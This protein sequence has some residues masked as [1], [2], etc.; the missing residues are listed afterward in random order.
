MRSIVLITTLVLTLYTPYSPSQTTEWAF[1]LNAPAAA[2][3]LFPNERNPNAIAVTAGKDVVLI[4][5]DGTEAWR[6]TQQEAVATPATVA[7]LDSDSAPETVVALVN[8]TV[9]CLDAR[10]TEWWRHAFNT[11]AG[12]FKI[13]AAADL[14][15]EPGIET[16]AGFDDGWLNCLSARGGLLWRFYGDRFR[17]GGVA[18][19]DADR[20]GSPN[21]VYGTD[22]GHIYC[23]D[24]N[25]RTIWRYNELAPYGRSG[26]NIADLDTDG[27]PEV[28]ITR[29]NV[30]NATCLMA[31]DAETGAFRW[32]TQDV[33]QGY[34][35]SATVDLDKDGRLE[36]LHGDKGNNLYCENSD[37]SRRWKTELGG[38]GLFWAPCV[39]DVDGDRQY[40]IVAAVRDA[41]LQT[42]AC[43]YVV[44]SDGSVKSALPL[45]SSANAAPCV[46]DID[47][48]GQLEVIV[49]TEGPN[50][51][52]CL[53]WNASGQIVWPSLRGDSAMTAHSN[54]PLG[55]PKPVEKLTSSGDAQIETD[56]AVLGESSWTVSWST[57]AVENA[58]IEAVVASPGAPRVNRIIDL[59]VGAMHADVPIRIVRPIETPVTISLHMP[60]ATTP[61]WVAQRTVTPNRAE[62][63]AFDHVQAACEKA[64][65]A[66]ATARTDA[67][68]I[69]KKL[70]LLAAERATV[71]ALT[72]SGSPDDVIAERATALRQTA[73][74]L[75]SLAARLEEFWK[76]G[77]AGDFVLWQDPNP[78]DRFEPDATPEPFHTGQPI[79]VNAFGNEFED[80]VL[81]LLNA[82]DG[83]VDIRCEFAEPQDNAQPSPRRHIVLRQAIPVPTV[84]QDRVF[85]ALPELSRSQS[86]TLPP[87]EA[88]QLWAVVDTHGL[89]QGTHEF[90][91]RLSSLT[92]PSTVR[93]VPLCI[94]VWPIDLPDTVFA[95]INWSSFNLDTTSD[96][97]VKD[98]IDHGVS[99]I[100]GPPLPTVS[101]DERGQPVGDTDWGLFDKTLARVP[102]HFTLLFSA[103]PPR[104][105]PQGVSPAEESEIY[106]AGFQT[107]VRA[108]AQH[109]AAR[110]FDYRQWAFYPIDEPWNTGFTNIPQLKR[111]CEM[112]KRADSAAQNYADPAGLVRVEYLDEFKGLIDIWQPEMNLLKRD[113]RLVDWFTRN[114]KR[115]WAYEAPGPA[116]DLL[117]LGHYRAFAWLA[118]RFGLEGA[119]YWVYRGED[120]WQAT[121]TTDYSA[122]YPARDGVVPSRRWEADRDGVEDYRAL[123]LLREEIKQARTQGRT[124]DADRAQALMDR[125]VE[126]VVGWQIGKIDEITRMT[127]DYEIDFAKLCEYRVKIA[128][129]IVRLQAN[130]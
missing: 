82:S 2:P 60:G 71:A 80:I 49:A 50:Q 9:V 127:R 101:V 39:A 130:H 124:T 125:A 24:G 37:G 114:A 7:D 42:K 104:Q 75:E 31:L 79:M 85:D 99:V 55:T 34:V 53:S 110:G 17:V 76:C 87:G 66:A 91:L 57:P 11:P 18:I 94:N 69:L 45:G 72:K 108:L 70:A 121:G 8:G 19:A 52:Q 116:K 56:D 54:V 28:L 6:S 10:G 126:D 122:V 62:F 81:D 129:E 43:V 13:L 117:P 35:S 32:R 36:I 63:C 98:M 59:P 78:W 102:Q 26:P 33:M 112:V 95:K 30:G 115:F 15:V 41:E 3:T 77:G 120:N 90:T 106:F 44:G 88:R 27:K 89:P 12:G 47:G 20:D 4:H 48:D 29:S 65:L 73:R 113:P 119:G 22:N 68:G 64:V 38:R 100:Y 97:S 74:H 1:P 21:I 25:G 58:F 61:S 111:F 84:L 109:L 51:I 67:S 93:T 105:W 5:G 14:T 16:L 107:A 118:W 83:A 46:G 23:L 96:Q 128:E 123:W 86:L 40:E 103:P 92:K